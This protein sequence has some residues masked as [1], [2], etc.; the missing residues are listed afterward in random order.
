M[1]DNCIYPV[2]EVETPE[3]KGKRL[4]V[5]VIGGLQPAPEPELLFPPKTVAVCGR[6]GMEW[7]QLMMASCG[8]D[9]CPMQLRVSY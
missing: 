6:C 9:G 2:R 1:I 8:K 3:Q 7:K 5:P 4:G